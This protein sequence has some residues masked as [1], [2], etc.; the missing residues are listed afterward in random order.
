LEPYNIYKDTLD[1]TLHLQSVSAVDIYTG[2]KNAHDSFEK[3]GRY[4]LK[5][6]EKGIILRP[7]SEITND[8]YIDSDFAGLWD[9]EDRD[10][11]CHMH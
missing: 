1:Q 2:I 6:S 5:T 3:I 7:N 11:I 9:R 8:C 4:L 10:K